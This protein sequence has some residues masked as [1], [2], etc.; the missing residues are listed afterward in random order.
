MLQRLQT[1]CNNEIAYLNGNFDKFDSGDKYIDTEHEFSYDLDIFGKNS[2]FNRINR[3]IT[4]KGRDKLAS[5]LTQLCQDKQKINDN[6]MAITELSSMFEWRIK[7]MANPYIADNFDGLAR[8]I[9]N[10]TKNFF[11]KSTVPYILIGL[12]A[13][14]FLL[15]LFN[16]VTWHYFSA[17]FS[18]NLICSLLFFRTLSTT[19]VNAEMLHKEFAA[20]LNV[21]KD[22]NNANFKSNALKDLKHELFGKG[23]NSL[24]AFKELSKIL[25]MFDQRGNAII[26]LLLNGTILFDIILVK[27]M[28]SWSKKHLS[29]IQHWLDCIAEL[30]ALV[31]FGNYAYNNPDNTTAEILPENTTEIIQTTNI[32]HPFLTH[33][34]AVPNNFTLNKNNI[35]IVTG[36]N[37]AGKSTYLRTIGT[38][39]LLA[40]LG[41]PVCCASLTLYPAQLITSLRTS[42][43]L[44][45]G[46][47][48]F[49]AELK[50]LKR[51]IDLLNNGTE[52]FIILDEVLKGT[53]SEDKQKGSFDLIRQL[54]LLKANGLIA[55]HDLMLSRLRE[56][57]PEHIQNYCFEADITNDELTFSYKL[58][59]G[60]AQN[61][62]ACFLMKKMGIV[63]Q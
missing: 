60:V 4:Q 39:Y 54:I 13:T 46:E 43:S 24:D 10:N 45:D 21:L 32:Y 41:A 27:K 59:K 26:Y 63:I 1:I 7:F 8:Q 33:R 52:L 40:C 5:K 19:N 25:N 51:I 34:K 62:N 23:T 15:G 38:N 28:M 31:S 55:T 29:H 18:I 14:T 58:R 2:L 17:T 6:Q 30:D 35:A 48:Y 57:F 3:C 22:I 44:S 50:R 42:D 16:I 56:L 47:S 49:F 53:N 61:M 11:I 37:M 20:Y 36:A 12:A 9:A